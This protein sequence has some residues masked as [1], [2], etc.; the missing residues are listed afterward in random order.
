M[1]HRV[2]GPPRSDVAQRRR[3]ARKRAVCGTGR[4]SAS[5]GFGRLWRPV[6]YLNRQVLSAGLSS[7]STGQSRQHNCSRT[8][9][10][11]Q[12]LCLQPCVGCH[13]LRTL[14]YSST[15][16]SLLPPVRR[17][18]S[19]PLPLSWGGAHLVLG[20]AREDGGDGGGRQPGG[21]AA[22]QQRGSSGV[23]VGY[24]RERHREREIE[25]ERERRGWTKGCYIG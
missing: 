8:R 21:G 11:R 24:E 15:Y 4:G 12:E 14:G 5:A 7:A 17:A 2:H 20:A 6:P 25:R 13:A 9:P 3:G 1:D 22:L 16:P 10:R 23:T 18:V 19:L